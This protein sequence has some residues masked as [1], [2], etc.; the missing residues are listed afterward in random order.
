MTTT[1]LN[2][3][4][5][6][7]FEAIMVVSIVAFVGLAIG[8]INIRKVSLGV[9]GVVFAGIAYSALFTVDIPPQILRIIRDFGMVMF[10][11]SIGLQVGPGFVSSFR[12]SGLPLN[13]MCAAIV[14]LG[15]LVTCVIV[16]CSTVPMHIASGMFAGATTSTASLAAAQEVLESSHY[17]PH[18]STPVPAAPTSGDETVAVNPAPPAGLPASAERHRTL[19]AHDLALVPLAYSMAYPFGILGL[20]I[21]IALMK[22]FYKREEEN[23]G[24]EPEDA[25]AGTESLSTMS[26]EVSNPNLA[27]LPLREIPLAMNADVVVSR[28]LRRDKSVELAKPDAIIHTRDVLYAVGT[29]EGLKH[30]C[31]AVGHVSDV[32]VSHFSANIITWR[33]LVT[34][35]ESI[36]KS[37]E[38]LNANRRYGVAVTRVTRSEMEFSA[39]SGI[40]LQFG[41]TVVAAGTEEGLRKLAEELGNSVKRLS[42]PPLIPIFLGLIIGALFGMMLQLNIPGIPGPIKLGLTGGPLVIGILLSRI[43]RVG[44]FI[45]FLPIS[46]NILMR[47]FSLVLFLSCVGLLS[48]KQFITTLVDGDGLTWMLLSMLITLVPIVVVGLVARFMTGLSY[49]TLCGMLAGSMTDAAALTFA[50]NVTGSEKPTLAYAS[51]YPMAMILRVIIIQVMI[52]CFT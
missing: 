26:I 31:A 44:S 24:T 42:E 51:V 52:V 48:G 38:A 45:W 8:S 50:Q 10:V 41:D 7:S 1:N 32:D 11:Y 22:L 25:E 12:K 18:L 16:K 27:N 4:G 36:G 20:I 28:I 5:S 47:Q 46:A 19:D 13:L 39:N 21:V 6:I 40:T 14:L 15:A 3:G 34:K 49:S 29:P 33:I 37:V 30:F 43:G 23:Q 17:A 35:P 2:F 9:A